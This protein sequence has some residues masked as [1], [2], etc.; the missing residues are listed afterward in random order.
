MGRAVQSSD[1]VTVG[2]A[3]RGVIPNPCQA[4]AVPTRESQVVNR[5]RSMLNCMVKRDLRAT[6]QNERPTCAQG[7]LPHF[8][9]AV[10]N[11]GGR[12]LPPPGP[13]PMKVT[14]IHSV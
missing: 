1:H 4:I 3:A 12:P 7:W 9:A 13:S 2:L 14:V 5:C 10:A 8:S 6:R 11:C